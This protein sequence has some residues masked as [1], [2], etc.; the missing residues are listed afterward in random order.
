MKEKSEEQK[1]LKENPDFSSIHLELQKNSFCE[2]WPTGKVSGC[3]VVCLLTFDCTWCC[4]VCRVVLYCKPKNNDLHLLK[5][6]LDTPQRTLNL[7]IFLLFVRVLFPWWDANITRNTRQPFLPRSRS[8]LST[9]ICMLIHCKNYRLVSVSLHVLWAVLPT[10]QWHDIEVVIPGNVITLFLEATNF[11]TTLRTIA[12]DNTELSQEPCR[13]SKLP[14]F[15]TFFGI[16][17]IFVA[18]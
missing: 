8:L 18:V 10:T 2:G 9:Y 12:V 16:A 3:F 6:S 5:R 7:F 15:W 14:Q 11:A 4:L 17:S 13:S 1:F